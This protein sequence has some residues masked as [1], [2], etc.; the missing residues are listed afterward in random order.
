[1]GGDSG[2][3]QPLLGLEQQGAAA[4]P[5]SFPRHCFSVGVAP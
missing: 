3:F 5:A 4:V 2:Q 1:M